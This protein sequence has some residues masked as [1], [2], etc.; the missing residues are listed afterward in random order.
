MIY[1][2]TQRWELFFGRGTG[3]LPFTALRNL[4]VLLDN[5]QP[6]RLKFLFTWQR[7]TFNRQIYC[8]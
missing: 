6:G 7:L 8:P 2:A 5:P 4:P 3:V 1:Q